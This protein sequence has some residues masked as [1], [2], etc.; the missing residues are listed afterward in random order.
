[1]KSLLL[2]CILLMG[3]AATA[4]K[5]PPKTK[6]KGELV[7]VKEWGGLSLYIMETFFNETK[8]DIIAQIGEEEFNI[9]KGKCTEKGWPEGFYNSDNE[10]ERNTLK[11]YRIAA[12][13][14]KFNGKT[15]RQYAILRIPY[16]ENKGWK[17]HV[18]WEGN[19]YFLVP[20]EAV[21]TAQ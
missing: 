2:G 20:N 10:E 16:D 18:K 6:V 19:L 17:P 7:K 13:T 9:M 3:M 4:Q 1:M 12:Y 21:T 8:A 5:A 14:H 11:L 15:F